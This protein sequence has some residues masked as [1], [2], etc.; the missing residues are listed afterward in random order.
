MVAGGAA[1]PAGGG[2]TGPEGRL[3]SIVAV[4][5]I[6][7]TSVVDAGAPSSRISAFGALRPSTTSTVTL[8]PSA[9]HLVI[10]PC[11]ILCA[12]SIVRILVAGSCA[13]AFTETAAIAILRRTNFVI[14][15]ADSFEFGMPVFYNW[16]RCDRNS[17]WRSHADFGCA[18][19][20]QSRS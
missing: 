14:F 16:V 10:A 20:D 9:L 2:L 3:Y 15:I 7:A 17:H 8:Y 18:S 12:T 13:N 5:F 6:L 4:A 19:D 11:A 1:C